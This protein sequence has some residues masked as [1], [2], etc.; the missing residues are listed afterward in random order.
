M[1]SQEVPKTVADEG[2]QG[3]HEDESVK[4]L[5]QSSQIK[6]A[7]RV[8]ASLWNRSLTQWAGTPVDR[9]G[10]RGQEQSGATSSSRQHGSQQRPLKKDVSQ[11]SAYVRL[12]GINAKTWLADVQRREASPNQQQK[13]ALEMVVERCLKEAEELK[14]LGKPGSFTEPERAGCIHSYGRSH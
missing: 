8:T 11:T 9:T 2:E 1:S 6:S 5:R 12:K 3:R 14:S 10:E 4:V 13:V 7:V